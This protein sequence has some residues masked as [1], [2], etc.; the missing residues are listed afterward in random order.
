LVPQ[1]ALP[2]KLGILQI[3]V[4]VWFVAKILAAHGYPSLPLTEACQILTECGL[5]IP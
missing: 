3:L 2:K 5:R 1:V 4:F